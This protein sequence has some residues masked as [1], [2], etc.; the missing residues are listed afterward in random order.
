MDHHILPV[1]VVLQTHWDREWYASRET[2][3]ARLVRVLQRVIPLLETGAARS[4]F[5]DGQTA[6]LEDFGAE[7][8]EALLQ[9]LRALIRTG[10]VHLG[11]WYIA[12]R[13]CVTS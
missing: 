5:L 4:F 11:P 7:A 9:R 1:S 3:A 2:Y 12:S 10:R 6:A 8:E 13:C